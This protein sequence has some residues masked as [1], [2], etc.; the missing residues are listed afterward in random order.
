M[1]KIPLSHNQVAL[2]DDEDYAYLMQWKWSAMPSRP[3]DRPMRNDRSGDKL[4]TIL[5]YHV[6]ADRMGLQYEMIDHFDGDALNNQRSNL[7]VST[8]SQNLHNRGKPKSNTSGVKGVSLCKQTGRY[9]ARILVQGKQH[10]LGRFN[11]VDEAAA[12][13]QKKRHE[14]VGEFAHD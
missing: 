2:V 13:V 1:K 14:L 12:A 5:M 10:W 7:R 9:G 3:T 11:T 4:Q 8:C 6:I